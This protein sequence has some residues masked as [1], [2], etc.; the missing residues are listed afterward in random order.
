MP[1][2]M[3]A[4]DGS[5]Q[6]FPDGTSE[7]A[8]RLAMLAHDNRDA[9]GGMADQV[10]QA[11]GQVTK[12]F[13]D[14]M[15]IQGEGAMARASGPGDLMKAVGDFPRAIEIGNEEVPKWINAAH[16]ANPPRKNAIDN[17]FDAQRHAEWT[18]RMAR[19]FGPWHAKLFSDLWEQNPFARDTPEAHAMDRYNNWVALQS[20]K[21]GRPYTLDNLQ[22]APGAKPKA[23]WIS[24]Q[25]PGTKRR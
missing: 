6:S 18:A 7:P 11:V 16:A 17:E 3:R 25:T 8:I 10:R 1:I 19:E 21:E 13:S 14:G 5:I 9:W 20:V 22:L 15:R 2:N 4:K 24:G 23:P 12:A